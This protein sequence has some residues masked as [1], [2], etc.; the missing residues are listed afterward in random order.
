M[1]LLPLRTAVL[2]LAFTLGLEAWS[3]TR[4]THTVERKETA[5]GI[6][7]TYGVDLNALFELNPWAEGGIRKGDVLKI[8][9]VGRSAP[10]VSAPPAGD[11]AQPSRPIPS[12][13]KRD[14][15]PETAGPGMPAVL[16]RVARGEV[17]EQPMPRRPVPPTFP[18]DTLRVAVFLPFFSGQDS[19]GR[20]E[21]RLR[22]IALDCA[23]G[24]RLALD[25]GRRVGAHID[26]RFLDTGPDSSGGMLCSERDLKQFGGP[27]DLAIGPLK[28]SKFVEV[29]RW[30]G[31]EDAV[32]LALTDLGEGLGRNEPGVLMPFVPVRKRMEALA[33]HVASRHRGERVLFLA[34]GDIRNL[35]A[36]DAFRKAWALETEGDSLLFMSE[37][38][39][40]SK[41]LGSLRDSL[42]DVRR[43]VLVVPGGKANRSLAGVLQTEIQLGDT[44][45]FVLYADES[46]RSFDFLDP[47]VRERI[48]FTVV[49]GG[50]SLPDSS[51]FGP[52]D[53]TH[54]CLAQRMTQLRG[55]HCGTFGWMAHDATVDALGWGVG[56]GAAW[57]R[58][59]SAGAWLVHP[60]GEA[61]NGLHRFQWHPID[62][63]GSGLVNG[64]VRVLTQR[65]YQWVEVDRF[66]VSNERPRVPVAR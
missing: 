44:M 63:A 65:G 45:D 13:P 58:M 64:A 27:V 55:G 37:V 23:A 5:Y 43:N 3:Q 41:G 34:T 61:C 33:R 12:S 26:V 59:M 40:D 62:G 30:Q 2:A 9:A 15:L 22:D 49:D 52:L 29:L 4:V 42:S 54:F 24:I 19:L 50:G 47:E 8:P 53:S 36:E 10:V 56:H 38:A 48:G 25:T 28:R 1:I 35:D 16:E 20:Q 6:A 46:W 17:D 11:G 18:D 60:V 39:V 66:G 31:M 57:P 14:S 7:R 21:L 51:V 32:C